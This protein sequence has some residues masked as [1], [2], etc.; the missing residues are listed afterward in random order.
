MGGILHDS[1]E[2]LQ[3]SFVDP[4]KG[5]DHRDR[6]SNLTVGIPYRHRNR[7]I[8]LGNLLPYIEVAHG[9]GIGGSSVQYGFSHTYDIDLIKAAKEV[10]DFSKIA[11]LLLPGIG[12]VEDLKLAHAAG[13][14]MVRVATH[15]TEADVSAQHIKYAKNELGMEVVGF[16]M[17]A[18]MTEPERLVEEALKMQSYGADIIYVTDSAGALLPEG[19]TARVSALV[20]A[21]DVPV[22]FHA[23]NNLGLAIGNSLAAIEAGATYVDG[24]VRA[25]GAGSGNTQTEVLA[26]VLDKAGIE[27]GIDIYG[28]QD[29]AE[30]LV[31]PIMEAPQIV[32]RDNISL[33]YAGVYSSFRLFAQRAGKKYDLEPRDILT[34]L[35]RI[36]VVGGQEDM[37]M[38]VAAR[39]AAERA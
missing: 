29:V 13:A 14:Y 12:T 36:G 37:V 10:A 16:L 3:L 32:D 38:D 17:M 31:A 24:S 7:I 18:H 21:L 22:G 27:T 9:D 2:L 26:A 1:D 23:H 39:M 19:V 4:R 8:I 30:D 25:L 20:E 35:G 5:P 15:S 33:G 34:E 28:I 6:A 11:V